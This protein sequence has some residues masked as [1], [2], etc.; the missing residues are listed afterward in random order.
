[1]RSTCSLL[2]YLDVTKTGQTE[3]IS[4]IVWR[5]NVFGL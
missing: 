1:M 3:N 5:K 4:C 2:V